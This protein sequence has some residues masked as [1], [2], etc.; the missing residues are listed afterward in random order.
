MLFYIN[1]KFLDLSTFLPALFLTPFQTSNSKLIIRRAFYVQRTIQGV[2]LTDGTSQFRVGPND[3]PTETGSVKVAKENTTC[4][5]IWWSGSWISIQ[6][7][8]NAEW[9]VGIN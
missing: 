5:F 1:S 9:M 8:K 4:F 7:R 3:A 2:C 6:L